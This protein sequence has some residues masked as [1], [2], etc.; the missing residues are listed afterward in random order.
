MLW[1][2]RD[3]DGSFPDFKREVEEAMDD[4]YVDNLKLFEE[5]TGED[6]VTALEGFLS[7]NPQYGCKEI[8]GGHFYEEV[9]L[10]ALSEAPLAVKPRTFNQVLQGA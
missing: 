5:I 8:A 1:T 9:V 7:E 2:A 6:W 3:N 4:K 10:K